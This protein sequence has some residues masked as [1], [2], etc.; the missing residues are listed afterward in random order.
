MVANWKTCHLNRRAGIEEIGRGQE[1]NE[2]SPSSS[3]VAKAG[4]VRGENG[5]GTVGREQLRRVD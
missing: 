5:K 2:T 4:K 1:R 3:D